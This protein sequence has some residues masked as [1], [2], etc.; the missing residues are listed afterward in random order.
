MELARTL[1][2]VSSHNDVHVVL[3]A[4]YYTQL[5]VVYCLQAS[6]QTLI[7][8]GDILMAGKRTKYSSV[9]SFIFEI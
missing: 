9:K 8:N 6:E 1:S 4:Q 7:Q 5:G 3:L 2:K